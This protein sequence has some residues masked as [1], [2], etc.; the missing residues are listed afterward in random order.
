MSATSKRAWDAG[1]GRTTGGHGEKSLFTFWAE[2]TLLPLD[3]FF[4]LPH[5]LHQVLGGD[6]GL[7][8]KNGMAFVLAG[9]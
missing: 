9:G 8:H 2:G 4:V 6:G 5:M 3:L 7:E 1:E